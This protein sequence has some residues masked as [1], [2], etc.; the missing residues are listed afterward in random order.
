MAISFSNWR[1]G[2]I[3]LMFNCYIGTF[4]E[5]HLLSCYSDVNFD[6]LKVDF[7]QYDVFF[8]WHR[9]FLGPYISGFNYLL[10]IK[11][12]ETTDI[13]QTICPIGGHCNGMHAAC[14]IDFRGHK[15]SLTRE[16]FP[17]IFENCIKKFQISMLISIF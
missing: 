3:E 5:A 2:M 14:I 17:N 12:Y 8:T 4:I 13:Y 7:K 6:T 10:A 1:A 11:Y 15:I 9:S 16:E